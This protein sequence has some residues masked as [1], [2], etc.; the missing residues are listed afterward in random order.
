MNFSSKTHQQ[1]GKSED[2]SKLAFNDV[3]SMLLNGG[4][5]FLSKLK[6]KSL[7]VN[8]SWYR[9]LNLEKRR[10]IDAV[11][12]TIDKIRSA[13]LLKVLINFTEKLLQAIGGI[14]GLIGNLAYD[15]QAFGQ[16]LAQRISVVGMGWGNKKAAQWANDEGFIRFL[17]VT[18]M[19]NLPIFKVNKL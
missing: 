8:N 17:T 13:L 5:K 10:F 7:R 11:I 14:R 19:N 12:Q 6:Q 16:P 18:D 9:V 3:K 4:T 2:S 15:M 1:T